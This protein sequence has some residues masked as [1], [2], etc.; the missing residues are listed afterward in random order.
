MAYALTALVFGL[1]L[2]HEPR[3]SAGWAWDA[4]NAVGFLAFA[5]MLYLFIDVGT[6]RRNRIHQW[7]SYSVAGALL[8]HVLWLIATDP[9]VWHYLA[10]DAP[11]YMHTG[12]AAIM[13]VIA[14]IVLA[15]PMWRRWWGQN[16]AAFRSWHYALSALGV[17]LAVS[18]IVGTGFYVSSP[19]EV[20][21]YAALCAAV[22]LASRR[23][24]GM[25][26]QI[27][28]AQ[29]S[30]VIALAGLF[31]GMKALPT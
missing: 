13:L 17:G 15:L 1:S 29:L 10:W 11:W 12:L 30:G 27:T 9:T 4:A 8:I 31:I 19:V 5:G 23:A 28:P 2:L 18:H 22:A 16:R 26:P 25:T 7:V 21:L 14:V 6:G 20:G 24:S 3:A